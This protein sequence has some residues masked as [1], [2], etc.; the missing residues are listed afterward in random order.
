MFDPPLTIESAQRIKLYMNIEMASL[1]FRELIGDFF[2]KEHKLEIAFIYN[3]GHGRRIS[4]LAHHVDFKME[5]SSLIMIGSMLLGVILGT[6]L[7]FARKHT[8][9]TKFLSKIWPGTIFAI[10]GTIILGIGLSLLLWLGRLQVFAFTIRGSYDNPLVI[11]I[12]G[13]FAT[14]FSTMILERLKKKF[15]AGT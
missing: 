11:C 12:I 8:P 10:V 6:F 13:V 3:D 1:S 4:D 7:K 5:A 14:M 9:Q 2:Q 15:V